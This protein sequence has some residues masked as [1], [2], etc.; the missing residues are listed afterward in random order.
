MEVYDFYILN[1]SNISQSFYIFAFFKLCK[2]SLY[3]YSVF[4]RYLHNKNKN[5]NDDK[6]KD[7]NEDEQEIK[8]TLIFTTPLEKFESQFKL[9]EESLNYKCVEIFED[10]QYSRL[11]ILRKY[12]NISGIYLLHNKINGKQYVGS[13]KNLGTRLTLYFTPSQLKMKRSISLA[14][15]KYG[16]TNFSCCILKTLGP[17]NSITKGIL[18]NE[19]QNFIDLF[20]DNLTYNI[21]KFAKNSMGYKHTEEI[22]NLMS[23]SR[24]GEKNP[25]YNLPKSPEFIAFMKKSKAGSANPQYGVIK[26]PETI[27]KL[28][29]KVYTY[30]L[31]NNLLV[32]YPS[33]MICRKELH[34]GYDTIQKYIDTGKPFK[35]K[36]FSSKPLIT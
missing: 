26:T 19:E 4:K 10:F 17:S 16:H 33:K 18:L 1:H 15:M 34:I 35:G 28:S 30:D 13:G 31:D 12:K 14:L 22:K 5:I 21:L 24:R 29:K 9:T 11:E 36:I 32:I 7:K 20:K 2:S 6:I 27:E 3:N 25:M 23:L 8:E